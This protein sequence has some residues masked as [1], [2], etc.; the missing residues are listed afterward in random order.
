MNT[1]LSLILR[2]EPV[3]N[4]FINCYFPSNIRIFSL[5]TNNSCSW[6]PSMI[7]EFYGHHW[8]SA[9]V[10]CWTWNLSC[11]AGLWSNEKVVVTLNI[12]ATIAAMGT[13][14]LENFYFSH[15]GKTVGAF[16]LQQPVLHLEHYEIY[17]SGRISNSVSGDFSLFCYSAY[18]QQ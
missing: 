17:S 8:C 5:K 6:F 10:Q 15:L 1:P 12:H 4:I 3:M 13:Y 11:G 2:I 18:L 14:C 16:S 7:Y 9:G